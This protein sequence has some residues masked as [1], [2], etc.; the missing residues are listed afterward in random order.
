MTESSVEVLLIIQF[1]QL[2]TFNFALRGGP[3]MN[4]YIDPIYYNKDVVRYIDLCNLCNNE[5][6][7]LKYR[8]CYNAPTLRDIIPYNKH[9]SYCSMWRP[10]YEIGY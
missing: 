3:H 4:L 7:C 8:Y 5:H 10:K 6:V 2:F 1:I 9:T